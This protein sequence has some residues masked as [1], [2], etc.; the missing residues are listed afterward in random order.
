[1]SRSPK[2]A[3]G[4]RKRIEYG[5]F[6]TPAGLA[7][8]VC[9]QIRQ[10]GIQPASLVEPT[11][12]EGQLLQAA[13]E[14]FPEA[15]EAVGLDIDPGHVEVATSRLPAQRVRLA[16]GDFF[17]TDWSR[18]LGGLPEPLLVVGNPPWTTSAGM[19]CVA[20]KNL[21]PK[22]NQ[23]RRRGIEAITGK[24]NFDISQWMISHLLQA[25]SGRRAALAM[26]CKTSVARKVLQQAWREGRGPARAGMYLIDAREAFGAAVDASLL[27][28]ELSP[29][30]HQ[31][32]C[33]LH[34]R[35]LSRR[36]AQRFGL[37]GGVLVAD[38]RGFARSRQYLR[39]QGRQG[40]ATRWRSGIKHDCARVM[41]LKREGG[42]YVNGLGERV[43]LEQTY[44]FPL[45]KSS[46]LARG[47]VGHT[48]RRM[49]VPQQAV[50]HDTSVIA[51][52]APR[53][54]KYLQRH[55]DLLDARASKVY[56]GRPRFSVFG[57]GE[58]A[59]APWKVAISGLYKAFYFRVVGPVQGKPV[60]LDDTAY[61]I[62]C[63]SEARA[64][65]LAT[66]L[67]SAEAREL[68]NSLVFWDAKR[69]IT[70]TLL[71]RLDLDALQQ[72]HE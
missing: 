64:R 42:G 34:P 22:K 38:L 27:L 49:L 25:L 45:L 20:G 28:C 43:R 58:Y 33:G 4:R 19:S 66:L 65:G 10:R 36:A 72:F 6:Q 31:Q 68:F 16:Q 46:D 60:V 53:T 50:N 18:L 62:P 37:Q 32:E 44:L 30:T 9:A 11:C 23:E 69:P 3:A 63:E 55:A 40:A 1:L 2:R 15:R 13:L 21:P 61:F 17:R 39:G 51:R 67:D 57:V 41:E 12:G 14:A 47:A 7:S 54:W 24:S 59:F 56:R 48:D 71:G 70:A 5:D 26:L 8:Q 52:Q 35:I 29:H